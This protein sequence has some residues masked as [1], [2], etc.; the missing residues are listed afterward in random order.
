MKIKFLLCITFFLLCT[1]PSFASHIAG[2]DITVKWISGNTFEITL[3]FYRDCSQGNAY[4]DKQVHL[5]I[6]DLV[7]NN[8]VSNG[9]P[10]YPEVLTQ[11][12]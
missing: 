1:L 10:A 12:Q 3:T 8:P 9:Q 5:G 4:F 2:G 7:T 11:L 6:Y